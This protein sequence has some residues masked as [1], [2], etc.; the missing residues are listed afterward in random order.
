[1]WKPVYGECLCGSRPFIAIQQNKN[2][3]DSPQ[4]DG[5]NNLSSW[6]PC[7]SDLKLFIDHLQ[8][9]GFPPGFDVQMPSSDTYLRGKVGRSLL[10]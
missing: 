10:P 6:I 8:G 1:M 2:R 7:L 5:R 9:V 3:N 4:N